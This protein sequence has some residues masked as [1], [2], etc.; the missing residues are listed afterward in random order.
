MLS[1]RAKAP[2]GRGYGMI[3]WVKR[4]TTKDGRP[5]WRC[6]MLGRNQ[7][8]FVFTGDIEGKWAGTK[9]AAEMEAMKEEERVDWQRRR[10]WVTVERTGSGFPIVA[11]WDAE[12]SMEP[13]MH[14]ATHA[15]VLADVLRGA[16][17]HEER[18]GATVEGL[19]H[20]WGLA[21]RIYR[22][23]WFM[24]WDDERNI[25]DM[26]DYVWDGVDERMSHEELVRLINAVYS[27]WCKDEWGDCYEFMPLDLE[28]WT[29]LIADAE[30]R[31][32]AGT[33]QCDWWDLEK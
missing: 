14:A 16:R 19:L 8:A 18:D 24:G 5:F 2:Y 23:F 3:A 25:T 4:G 33:D 22:E 21:A 27:E 10:Q 20:P 13:Y 30:R 15:K 7:R 11:K 32:L 1:G 31:A 6:E 29:G 28:R 12:F 17:G 26:I 9:I